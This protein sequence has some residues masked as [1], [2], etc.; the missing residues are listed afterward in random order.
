[1]DVEKRVT[2]DDRTVMAATPI[3]ALYPLRFAQTGDRIREERVN[4]PRKTAAKPV[5]DPATVN[6]RVELATSD[7]TSPAV[8][9]EN[10]PAPVTTIRLGALGFKSKRPKRTY[11]HCVYQR[12]ENGTSRSQAVTITR[13]A[14]SSK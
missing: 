3:A 8:S 7:N 1:M 10:L 12:I 11:S 9:L 4:R 5:L 14:F 2:T 13:G 6:P